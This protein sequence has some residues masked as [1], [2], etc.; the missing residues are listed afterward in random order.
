MIKE[1]LIIETEEIGIETETKGEVIEEVVLDQETE[2]DVLDRD[3]ETDLETEIVDEIVIAETEIET[4][5]VTADVEDRVPDHVTEIAIVVNE[6]VIEK[7][8][9]IA[10]IELQKGRDISLENS[11]TNSISKLLTYFDF[12]VMKKLEMCLRITR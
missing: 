4:E 3:Q 10:V 8:Q 7:V 6:I 1:N 12:L 9:E 2:I 11:K 5:T